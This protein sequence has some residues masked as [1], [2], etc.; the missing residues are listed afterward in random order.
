MTRK[1]KTL[2]VCKQSE[3][4]TASNV[5]AAPSAPRSTGNRMPKVR[6]TFTIEQSTLELL[7][8]LAK[9]A[10]RPVSNYLETL[11]LERRRDKQSKQGN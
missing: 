9:D 1:P 5:T 10:N 3:I 4:T 7:R 2:A 8:Q 6:Y 11:V